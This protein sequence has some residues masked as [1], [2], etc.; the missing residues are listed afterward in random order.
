MAIHYCVRVYP[1][2]EAKFTIRD[3][4][5]LANWLDYN[6]KARPG[7]TLFVDGVLAGP[8]D[9]GGLSSHEIEHVSEIIGRELAE[10]V[11]DLS[12][13]QET[14]PQVERY[15]G[16]TDRWNGYPPENSRSSF[17]LRNLTPPAG[18]LGSAP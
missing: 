18:P 8:R 1:N 12:R 16:I 4:P 17:K 11:H 5:G 9:I 14:G 6:R 7:N 13:A 10:G 2:G 3:E 15:G